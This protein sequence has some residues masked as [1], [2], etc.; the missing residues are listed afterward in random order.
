MPTVE[1]FNPKPVD[2]R[3]WSSRR[4]ETRRLYTSRRWRALRMVVI[5]DAHGICAVC[6]QPAGASGHVD[7]I[8][9]HDGRVDAFFDRSNLQ[10]LC[11]VCHSKKTRKERPPMGG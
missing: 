5:R 9:P 4:N 2:E 8:V 6:Q 10:L 1:V 3:D 7:H 11:C